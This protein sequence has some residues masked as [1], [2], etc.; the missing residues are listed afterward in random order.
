MRKSL[1]VVD[2]PPR[3]P[4]GVVVY[5]GPSA[6]NGEHVVAVA[7]NI[8]R[9]SRNGKTG[10]V[11]QVYV[12][13]AD[14]DPVTAVFS[15]ADESV[16]GDCLHRYK[17]GAGSCYV[18][19]VQGPLGVYKAFQSGSYPELEPR[20]AAELVEGRVVR[21]GAY[22]DPAAV[23]FDVWDTLLS[24]ASGWS[25]YTHQWRRAHAQPL[26]DFCMAS[27][28][29]KGQRRAA[30]EKGWRTYRIRHDADD[31]LDQGEFE[32]P[33]SEEHGFRLTCEECGACCGGDAN[34]ASPAIIAHGPH[35]KVVRLRELIRRMNAKEKYRN[36]WS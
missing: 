13:P 28:E 8:R 15:G 4:Q 3:A 31:P 17:G 6:I 36:V 34:R 26:K 32:C 21:L 10:A 14:V 7:T 11:V 35:W 9:G 18:N 29:T 16:C 30:Q 12:I 2:A 1:D 33:A 25:G 19:P 27:C 20:E 23:P 22:G 24:C 5:D